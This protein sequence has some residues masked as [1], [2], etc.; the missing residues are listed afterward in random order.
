MITTIIFDWG[1]VLIQG[2]HNPEVI[3]LFCKKYKRKVKDVFKTIDNEVRNM[4][5]GKLTLTQF[6]NKINKKLNINLSTKDWL[7]FL[8]YSITTNNAIIPLIKSLKKSYKIL[9]L[10]NNNDATIKIIK[11]TQKSLLSLFDKQYYSSELKVRKP[12]R[13][14]YNILLKKEKLKPNEC[15][16]IDDKPKNIVAANKLGMKGIIYKNNS[17]LKSSLK[18]LLK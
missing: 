8:E 12:K 7:Y 14:I 9:I 13:K 11:R 3:N 1:G 18:K 2:K 6:T 15:I 17:Q 10:S 5:R 4:D 16:F